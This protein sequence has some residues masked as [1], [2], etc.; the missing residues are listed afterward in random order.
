MHTFFI[1][2]SSI[3]ENAQDP[4]KYFSSFIHI[5]TVFNHTNT[6]IAQ[7]TYVI[8]VQCDLVSWRVKT[9]FLA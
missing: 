8:S 5:Y 6:S 1:Q 3:F 7:D 9:T 4:Y 2:Y